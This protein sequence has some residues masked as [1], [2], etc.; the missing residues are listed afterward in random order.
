VAG[1]LDGEDLLAKTQAV[2]LSTVDADGWPR[3]A[4]LSAGDTL[5]LFPDSGTTAGWTRSR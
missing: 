3:A 5:M 2:R 1:Y 4:L